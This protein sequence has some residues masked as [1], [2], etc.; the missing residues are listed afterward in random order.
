[1]TT[2][3]EVFSAAITSD[4]SMLCTKHFNFSHSVD[5]L[6]IDDCNVEEIETEFLMNTKYHP[7]A[8]Q[9]SQNPIQAL[10]KHTF[11][12]LE[13]KW[14]YLDGNLIEMIDPEAFFN[15]TNVKTISLQSNR[16]RMY[17]SDFFVNVP[18]L[19]TLSLENN[20]IQHLNEHS[21]K[22]LQVDGSALY[23][24]LNKISEINPNV[25]GNMTADNL[26]VDLRYNAINNIPVKIFQGRNF[27][28]FNL[29]GNQLTYLRFEL[30][31]LPKSFIYEAAQVVYFHY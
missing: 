12:N 18:N 22:F 1:M 19:D 30:N 29:T 7:S 16:I 4:M 17:N 23:L 5:Y 3:F 27:H 11:K 26:T 10:R 14:F 24:G 25:F 2:D 15:L 28:S 13:I 9:I 31:C 20:R 6:T 8:L 21:F